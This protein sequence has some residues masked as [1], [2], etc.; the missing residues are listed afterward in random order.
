MA[1]ELPMV[2]KPFV[3][4][5]PSDSQ[6]TSEDGLPQGTSAALAPIDGVA[7]KRLLRKLDLRVVPIV[8]FLYMLAFVDRINIGNARIQGLEKDLHM[9]GHD[10]NI[11]LFVFFIPYILIEVPS[12]LYIRK[13]N[14]STWL[15]SIMVLWG[16]SSP[17]CLFVTFGIDQIRHYHCLSG[18]YSKLCWPGRLSL[19][20]W[21]LRGWLLSR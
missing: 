6:T 20:P 8:G 9:K 4:N 2:E 15:S 19:L 7:D 1:T 21:R 5:K 18:C 12:N 14:P 16:E 10:Y 3:I 17:H 13:A 11:A